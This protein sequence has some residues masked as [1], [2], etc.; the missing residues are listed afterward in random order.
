M[1]TPY[2]D[3]LGGADPV[4]VLRSSLDQYRDTGSR[5]TAVSW[6]RPWAPGKWTAQQVM[7]HVAQ[8]EM[9]F[10]VR[11]RC[12]IGVRGYVV[13][14]V[15]QDELMAAEERAV[16]GPTALAAFEATRRMNIALAASLTREQRQRT[17]THPERGVIAVEDLLQTLAGHPVHHWK[18]IQVL[19]F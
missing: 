2:A 4:D 11:V 6:R 9:I 13:Q 19:G 5:L 15:D 1:P 8:W 16:D 7:L 17:C 10:S 3:Q 14:P 18:Q 12:A